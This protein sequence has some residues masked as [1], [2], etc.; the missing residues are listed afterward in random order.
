MTD[1]IVNGDYVLSGDSNGLE[2]VDYIDEVVQNARILLYTQ[3]GRFYPNKNFGSYLGS[4]LPQPSDEYALA[5][6][7]MALEGLDGV[8]VDSA[9]VQNGI[10]YVDMTVNK[11]K[12]Q[13]IQ[14]IEDYI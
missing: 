11:G 6:A 8:F 10:I 13:V 12:V 1:K 7:R 3:R 2:Q 4:A 5:Y 9:R 14:K